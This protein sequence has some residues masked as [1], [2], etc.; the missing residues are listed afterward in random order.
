MTRRKPGR[1]ALLAGLVVSAVLSSLVLMDHLGR[2][3]EALC[4]SIHVGDSAASALA[5]MKASDGHHGLSS[6]RPFAFSS[7]GSSRLIVWFS[8]FTG[9]RFE[10]Q[11]TQADGKVTEVQTFHV[12]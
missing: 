5:R 11:V 8:V 12:N 10:C 1:G 4:S 9:D 7:T 2:R 6:E 3:A